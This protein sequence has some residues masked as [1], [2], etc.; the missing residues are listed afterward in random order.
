MFLRMRTNTR[1]LWNLSRRWSTNPA[2]PPKKSTETPSEKLRWTRL[3]TFGPL[4]GFPLVLTIVVVTDIVNNRYHRD[5]LEQYAPSF[6]QFVRKHHGFVEEDP[7]EMARVKYV[8]EQE[9]KSVDATIRLST[10]LE[11][12]LEGLDA[13]LPMGKLA[14]LVEEKLNDAGEGGS[15]SEVL[16]SLTFL[17]GDDRESADE[18]YAASSSARNAGYRP[19]SNLGESTVTIS[20]WQSS[21]WSGSPVQSQLKSYGR[22]KDVNKDVVL[23]RYNN[24][25]MDLLE[26]LQVYAKH[27]SQLLPIKNADTTGQAKPRRAVQRSKYIPRQITSAE[28]NKISAVERI[29]SLEFDIKRLEEEKREGTREIDS[30]DSDIQSKRAEITGLRRQYLNYF[31]YF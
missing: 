2:E 23:I 18:G 13:S 4:V 8:L 27:G 29:S 12:R 14:A 17:D 19:V 5:V 30:I 24:F 26:G 21:I 15:L 28:S 7:V 25:I 9:Q 1:A 20:P 10:G 11:L 31:Y 22:H 6:V 16:P 3:Q